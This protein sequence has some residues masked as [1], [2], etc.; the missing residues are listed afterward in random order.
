MFAEVAGTSLAAFELLISECPGG[1][2]GSGDDFSFAAITSKPTG[3]FLA[4]GFQGSQ[5]LDHAAPA[6]VTISADRNRPRRSAPPRKPG[7]KLPLARDDRLA[8]GSDLLKSS[9]GF[10]SSACSSAVNC[11]AT[12]LFLIGRD[13]L[14]K[15]PPD[16]SS[17]RLSAIDPA[18]GSSPAANLGDTSGTA[19]GTAAG[20]C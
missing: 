20:A 8:L 3:P 19:L 2:P 1:L 18:L 13:L 9:E 14:V 11:V 7:V 4:S 6:T 5:C 17:D 16:A 12:R 10:G 15:P